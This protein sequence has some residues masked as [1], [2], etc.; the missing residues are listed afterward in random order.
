MNGRGVPGCSSEV[1][2]VSSCRERYRKKAERGG[3]ERQI[4]R[5]QK[6]E[7]RIR[8]TQ[9]EHEIPQGMGRKQASGYFAVLKCH[10]NHNIKTTDIVLFHYL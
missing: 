5:S 2:S 10:S 1:P 7:G 6:E 3:G 4:Y 8:E 9:S